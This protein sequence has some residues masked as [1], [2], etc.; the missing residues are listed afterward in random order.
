MNQPGSE[1]ERGIKTLPKATFL[2]KIKINH[3]K[4]ENYL[5]PQDPMPANVVTHRTISSPQGGKDESVAHHSKG[6]QGPSSKPAL[7]L[8]LQGGSC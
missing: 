6:S 2:G 7:A 5:E 3:Y 4:E 8:L 1:E